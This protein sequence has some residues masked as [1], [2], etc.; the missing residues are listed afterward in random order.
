M[1][2]GEIGAWTSFRHI[3]EENAGEAARAV[4][5]AGYGTFWLG[6]SPRLAQMRPLLEGSERARHRHLDRQHLGL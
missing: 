3:G 4:E 5:A 2:F 1:E 6:G